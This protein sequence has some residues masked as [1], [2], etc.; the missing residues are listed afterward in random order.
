MFIG[1]VPINDVSVEVEKFAD[2]PIGVGRNPNHNGKIMAE[3][4]HQMPCSPSDY[5]GN[6][7]C[8]E[9]H[10]YPHRTPNHA[11]ADVLEQP[12]CNV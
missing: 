11:P 1:N 2:H 6:E 7:E 12:K 4:T 9:D 3:L 5:N 10:G 8:G